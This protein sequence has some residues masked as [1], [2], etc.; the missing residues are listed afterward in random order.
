MPIFWAARNL[1]QQPVQHLF[2]GYKSG[3]MARPKECWAMEPHPG[4]SPGLRT[5]PRAVN[6]F[7]ADLDEAMEG[8][9]SQCPGEPKVAGSV[10][11][12]EGR[13]ALQRDLERLDPGPK[14]CKV[15]FYKA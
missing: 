7:I 11:L 2:P 6:L 14:S 1:I 13:R 3:W 12:L 8:T 10:D 4:V 9:L 15:R 5:G